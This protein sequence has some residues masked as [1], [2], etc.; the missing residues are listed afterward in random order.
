MSQKIENMGTLSRFPREVRDL[1]WENFCFQQ[2]KESTT[3]LPNTDLSILRTCKQI[4]DEVEPFV[5]GKEVLTFTLEPTY[6]AYSWFTMESRLGAYWNVANKEA[7]VMSGF[8]DIPYHKLSSVKIDVLAPNTADA[9]QMINLHNK[10]SA[11]TTL[12]TESGNTLPALE[13]TLKNS[14]HGTWIHE[15]GTPQRS[16]PSDDDSVDYKAIM[17]P[18]FR[19]TAT[20][21][22]IRTPHLSCSTPHF[23]PLTQALTSCTPDPHIETT[24]NI[25]WSRY[26]GALDNLP[27]HTANMLRRERFACWFDGNLDGDSRYLSRLQHLHYLGLTL[28]EN[29]PA[30]I[31]RRYEA[32]LSWNPK[33]VP[34]GM[35]R[36]FAAGEVGKI[37]GFARKWDFGCLATCLDRMRGMDLDDDGGE[38]EEEEEEGS[39][40][41]GDA[42]QRQRP[43]L[44]ERIAAI[45]HNLTSEWWKS[46]WETFYPKGIPPLGSAQGMFVTDNMRDVEWEED[47]L[48]EYMLDLE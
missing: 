14:A 18:F 32:C 23:L 17:Y 28:G 8:R 12:I 46:E 43:S 2:E 41:A 35:L 30:M 15:D 11:L 10:V 16:L 33:G 34:M 45:P 9:G 38:E 6:D 47:R 44:Q 22:S 39:V 5:Y 29:A 27:G 20:T 26:D 21:A 40:E 7:A 3:T 31:R 48:E 4:H 1:I 36:A 25:I 19:L 13:I 37:K 24:I 42:P